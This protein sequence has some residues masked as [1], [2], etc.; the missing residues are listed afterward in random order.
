ML[1]T[2]QYLGGVLGKKTL[3]FEAARVLFELHRRLYAYDSGAVWFGAY[4][5]THRA[6]QVWRP[7]QPPQVR[8]GVAP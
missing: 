6:P 7:N 4:G 5:A 2:N 8:R 3:F 1:L